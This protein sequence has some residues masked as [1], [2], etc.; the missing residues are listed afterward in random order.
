MPDNWRTDLPDHGRVV[1]AVTR[2]ERGRRT[3]IRAQHLDA[4]TEEQ[5]YFDDVYEPEVTYDEGRDAYYYTEGW[6][7]LID[8]WDELSSVYV[9]DPVICWQPL[10]PLPEEEHRHAD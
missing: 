1:L 6:Y 9:N 10:P 7:E 4:L 2:D 3:I 5:N 8:N